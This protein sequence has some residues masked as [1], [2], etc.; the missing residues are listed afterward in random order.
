MVTK[1]PNKNYI[2]EDI[3]I[4]LIM[5]SAELPFSSEFFGLSAFCM[6]NKKLP[7]SALSLSLSPSLFFFTGATTHCGFVFFSPLAR[8]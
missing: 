8:L 7:N 4:K 3:V 1:I 5:T 6:K 2:H